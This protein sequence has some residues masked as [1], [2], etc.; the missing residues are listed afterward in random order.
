MIG[1]FD[2]KNFLS[3]KK[4]Q[5]L[6]FEPIA[7]MPYSDEY[8]IEVADG[9]NLLKIAT[10]YGAN[11]SGKSNILVALSFFKAIMSNIPEDKNEQIEYYPF[12]LDNTSLKGHSEMIMEF[13]LNRSKYRL[14]IEFDNKRIYSEKLEF[15]P[16]TQPALLYNRSYKKET[17]STDIIF[18]AKLELSKNSQLLIIGNTINN[19]S[20]IATLGRLNLEQSKLSLVY[21]FFST[22]FNNMLSPTT[23]MDTYIKD[24]IENDT[25]N[26]LKPFIINILKASDFNITD[27]TLEK[28]L[29]TIN[30]DMEKAIL[31]SPLPHNIKDEMINKGAIV[32]RK[33]SFEHQTEVGKFIIP[34]NLES[35]GT[36]RYLGLAVLLKQL[37]K[38]NKIIIIDEIE[39]SLHYEILAYFIKLFINNSEGNSQLIFSTHDINLLDENFIRRDTIWFTHKD[40]YGE[41]NISRLSSLGLR[42]KLSPY[43]AYRQG[44]LIDLPL[45]GS[46]YL[47]I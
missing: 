8:L 33:L 41:T 34:E 35:S 37:I 32:D 6:S 26:L 10:I 5:G 38:D 19:C 21:D 4:R 17:D 45:L 39:S 18:G 9:I 2:F 42:K 43:N 29:I 47:D 23:S 1:H 16:S 46:S 20:V 40:N 25:S 22:K 27:L 30:K 13:Y 7:G 31:S 36:Y 3:I 28:E 44:K 24:E 15:Y 14:A 11:A 12:M